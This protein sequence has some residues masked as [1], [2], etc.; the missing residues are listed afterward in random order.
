VNGETLARILEQRGQNR[1]KRENREKR[2][3]E[4][5]EEDCWLAENQRGRVFYWNLS[6]H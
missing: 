5:R 4:K 6:R 2:R 1:E 3:E